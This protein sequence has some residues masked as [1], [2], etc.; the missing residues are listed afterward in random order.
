MLK[1]HRTLEARFCLVPFLQGVR[2]SGFSVIHFERKRVGIGNNLFLR[3]W[4]ALS[5]RFTVLS[6]RREGAAQII[7][8]LDR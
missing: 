3:S 1:T 6:S 7:P 8:S 2:D 4:T 5:T